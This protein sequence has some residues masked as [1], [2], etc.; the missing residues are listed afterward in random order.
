[1][2]KAVLL[3]FD[4]TLVT[5]DILDVIC[6]IVGKRKESEQ[7]NREFHAGTRPGLDALITRINFLNGVSQDQINSKLAQNSYLMPGA[8]EL[9][10]YLKN[11]SIISILNSG[12]IQPVLKA[13]QEILGITHVVGAEPIMDGPILVG[14]TKDQFSGADFK[15]EGIKNILSG[16]NI[17]ESETLA[18]GDSPADKN[19]FEFAGKSIA[20]NPK[21]N[22]AEFANFVINNDLREAINII[23]A[24]NNAK[25]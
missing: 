23:E 16:I 19:V 8:K 15:L 5:E 17:Q 9:L 20:I 14:I 3:D 4:G 18:I 6:E 1:M 11:N 10:E 7:I 13:Y 21:G 22:I 12:N 25:V 2:I 24:I